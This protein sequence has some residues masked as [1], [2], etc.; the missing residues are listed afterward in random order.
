M[1]VKVILPI[2]NDNLE[3]LW[4]EDSELNHFN[5]LTE[6]FENNDDDTLFFF[7]YY[8]LVYQNLEK[9]AFNNGLEYKYGEK[10][11][12]YTG[13]PKDDFIAPLIKVASLQSDPDIGKT[14]VR[15]RGRKFSLYDIKKFVRGIADFNIDENDLVQAQ[16]YMYYFRDAVVPLCGKHIVFPN[17]IA[18]ASRNILPDPFNLDNREDMTELFKLTTS[19]R[20]GGLYYLKERGKTYDVLYDY[21]TRSLYPYLLLSKLYPSLNKKPFHL[22]GFEPVKEGQ[23]LAFYHITNIRI[24]RKPT[25]IPSLWMQKEVKTKMRQYGIVTNNNIECYNI[26]EFEGWITSI[27]YKIIHRF[28]DVK[29]LD[30]DQTIIYTELVPGKK[31][32]SSLNKFYIKKDKATGAIRT[33]YKVIIDSYSGSLAM[34]STMSKRMRTLDDTG[35]DF[36][37]MGTS[38]PPKD[39]YAF[40]TAYGREFISDL[41]DKAGYKNV[42]SIDTDGIFTKNRILDKYCGE[43]IGSLRLDKIMYNAKWFG[44]KQYE[45]QDENKNWVPTIAGLPSYLYEHGKF[46]YE[47]PKI[48]FDKKTA[49]YK[50]VQTIFNLERN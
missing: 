17:S 43:G 9:W 4:Y 37:T 45:Y 46:D 48:I 10:T 11:I 32:F 26:P 15:Y 41:A 22:S 8:N 7:F 31:Y 50:K 23:E 28:Y 33:L 16:N 12:Y 42:I 21:D 36:F 38:E 18:S 25:G 34:G 2:I 3:I 13:A 19:S 14:R 27:D 24:K 30:I 29:I 49:S 44:Q 47:I 6:L 1:T 35:Y 40:M 5:N 39:I 20:L